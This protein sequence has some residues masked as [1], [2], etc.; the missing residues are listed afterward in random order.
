MDAPVAHLTR[1]RIPVPVPVVV[2]RVTENRFLL[3]R[4]KP[5]VVVYVLW[6]FQWRVS[7]PNRT[8]NSISIHA[9]SLDLAEGF[10]FVQKLFDFSLHGI[11]TLLRSD[12]ANFV[13]SPCRGDG[14]LALPLRVR[15]WLLNVDMLASF[16]RPDRSETVPVIAG[17]N[18]NGIDLRIGKQFTHVGERFCLRVSLF[19]RVDTRLVRI[20]N[21]A[22]VD[23]CNFGKLTHQLTRSASATHKPNIDFFIDVRRP[24]LPS[25]SKNRSSSGSNTKCAEKI[26]AVGGIVHMILLRIY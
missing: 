4:A 22:D 20:T 7:F 1:T 18:H 12:L 2:Q 16:H 10:L 13:I 3:C 15:K 8:A 19:N 17:R 23:A 24:E 25:R 6:N 9:G 14:L 11:A 5:Q 21:S 26:S